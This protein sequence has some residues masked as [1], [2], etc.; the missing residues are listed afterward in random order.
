VV[1][2]CGR[3]VAEYAELLQSPLA[4][5]TLH[6][7]LK[8]TAASDWQYCT[9]AGAAAQ[10]EHAQQQANCKDRSVPL[11]VSTNTV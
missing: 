2:N 8:G 9:S 5:V 11:L 4:R 3:V 10:Q 1:Q 7:L 6:A